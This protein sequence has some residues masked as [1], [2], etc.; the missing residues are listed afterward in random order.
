MKSLLLL[1]SL[2]PL[3]SG[4]TAVTV[5]PVDSNLDITY[6]CIKDCPETC[7]DRRL[8]YLIQDGF[9]RHGITTEVFNC[10]LPSECEYSL[11]YS[12]ERAWGMANYLGHAEIKLYRG[13]SQIGNAEYRL[14]GKAGSA[15]NDW[16]NIKS[17][18][19]PVID[20]LLGGPQASD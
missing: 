11:T 6:V 20:E 10:E 2:F 8:L 7:F 19:D 17:K 5:D 3:L 1:F 16:E 13:K 12:C 4:C 15:L 14:K 9:Q 18:I